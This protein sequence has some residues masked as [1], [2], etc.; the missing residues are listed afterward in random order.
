MLIDVFCHVIDNFGDAGVC[1]RLAR[2]LVRHGHAVRL[3]C[4][5][6]EVLSAIGRGVS[7]CELLS[8]DRLDAYSGS[9]IALAICGF[10]YRLPGNVA[11]ELHRQGAV[12]INLEY[13]S[14]E[15]WVADFHGCQSLGAM[16]RTW[17][18]FPGLTPDSGGVIIE[19]RVRARGPCPGHGS[20]RRRITLFA[21]E[22]RRLHGLMGML[23]GSRIP[24]E[25]EVMGERSAASIR[26]SLDMRECGLSRVQWHG[27]TFTFRSMV[28]QDEY[29]D[30]LCRSD[31]NLVR[32]EDSLVRAMLAG[33]PF[34]WQIYPQADNLHLHKLDCFISLLIEMLD[35]DDDL[36]ALF[37][38]Y[39][40]CYNEGSD[41]C[42]I[43][44]CPEVFDDFE[45]EYVR[46]ARQLQA[47]LLQ[48]SSL[49]D[50]MLSFIGGRCHAG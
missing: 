11:R 34:L 18:Y 6:P 45:Q 50:R 32:G 41:D 12:C 17:F 27:I 22:N 23:R 14:C 25:V 35:I 43:F 39:F 4:S 13:L 28:T 49:T 36:A 26:S 21:Y 1:L 16:P 31:L 20:G 46:I 33:R 47:M 7:D 10:S 40:M 48:Q 5:D 38:A 8:F 44:G 30:L 19:D 29:D 9:G 15:P 37:R 42:S 2:D 3:F 24:S